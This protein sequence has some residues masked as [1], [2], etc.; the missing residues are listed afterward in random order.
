[1]VILSRVSFDYPSLTPGMHM[2]INE[3]CCWQIYRLKTKNG[4]DFSTDRFHFHRFLRERDQT[5]QESYFPSFAKNCQTHYDIIF[6]KKNAEQN[7]QIKDYTRAHRQ[8][9]Q[10]SNQPN[11]REPR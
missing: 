8:A 10:S 4:A 11:F 7:M 5:V 2:H 3:A 9:G 6:S 1:M